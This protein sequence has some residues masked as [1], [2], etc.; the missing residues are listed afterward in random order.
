[1]AALADGQ[2]LAKTARI[3]SEPAAL[4]AELGLAVAYDDDEIAV[5]GQIFSADYRP[6][7]P[8]IRLY[9]RALAGIDRCLAVPGVADT[10]GTALSAPVL[11]AHEI[12]HHLDLARPRS[13]AKRCP[14]TSLKL[15]SWQLKTEV[16]AM[17]E[18][19][20]GR[21][22]ATLLGLH[23]H[24]KLLDLL[25][26]WDSDPRRASVWTGALEAFDPTCAQGDPV[27][28]DT[29]ISQVLGREQVDRYRRDGYLF[30]LPAIDAAQAVDARRVLEDFEK[31][32][33]GR[34]GKD[35]RHKPH[36]VMTALDRIVNEP[37][38]LD[39]VEAILG[40]NFLCW[41]SVLFTK[42][43]RGPAYVSWH[44]DATYWGLEPFDVVTA[45]VALSP[46]TVDSGC[47]RVIPGTHKGEVIDHVD[48]F[49]ANNLL[50]RGQEI[51]VKFDEAQAVD[52][53]LQPGQMSLHDVKLVHGSEPNRSND[54]RIGLAIRYIPTHVRQTMAAGDSAMLVRG[55]DAFGHFRLEP[56]PKSDF[57]P[58]A[59]ATQEDSRINRMRILMRP[60]R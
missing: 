11:L 37:R 9:T 20:A 16:P 23:C 56:S 41:E 43:A 10:L 26:L 27:M 44:Q 12:Y 35:Q 31:S 18:I 42:E 6:K 34:I 4:A 14:I 3:G 7:P 46:S 49:A 25:L 1:V 57:S 45:W 58:E 39:A 2:A 5:V 51:A 19:A 38:L 36:L 30:P 15:G 13:L 28:P 48:T 32:Q 60:T 17:A 22:A 8:R 47:M 53:V 40:P 21:F 54:R 59:I 29:V 55:V 50:S 24:P 52:L 33:G